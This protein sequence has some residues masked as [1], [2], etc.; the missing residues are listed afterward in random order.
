MP[1]FEYFLFT[2]CVCVYCPSYVLHCSLVRYCCHCST[3]V[4]LEKAAVHGNSCRIPAQNQIQNGH[5]MYYYQSE[6]V[7]VFLHGFLGGRASCGF[8]YGLLSA[9]IR[10][11]YFC[12]P[13]RTLSRRTPVRNDRSVSI[14]RA[15]VEIGFKRK[16][17]G[18]FWLLNRKTRKITNL[19]V[20]KNKK[21]KK[22]NWKQKRRKSGGGMK[23][24]FWSG[25]EVVI[26][27]QFLQ[28]SRRQK[29]SL[30]KSLAS[31]ILQ[32]D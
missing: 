7:F 29:T 22:K 26:T 11:L 14:H 24:E 5:Y 2:L 28:T 30:L 31:F 25:Y 6:F 19:L 18:T 32:E 27:V 10:R 20:H 13:P 3:Y 17:W 4:N 21:R 9:S 15:R 12:L 1:Q 8:R 16:Q 23:K